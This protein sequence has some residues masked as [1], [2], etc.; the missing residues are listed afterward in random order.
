MLTWRERLASLPLSVLEKDA[1]AEAGE[2]LRRRD[3]RLSRLE[4]RCRGE[5]S[6]KGCSEGV[7]C[8]DAGT[9]IIFEI[10]LVSGSICTLQVGAIYACIQCN[11]S[12]S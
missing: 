10:C 9:C 2:M 8:T 11:T 7:S 5:L 1:P 12:Y 3:M 4:P 6:S